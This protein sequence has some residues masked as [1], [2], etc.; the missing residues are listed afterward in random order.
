MSKIRCQNSEGVYGDHLSWNWFKCLRVY[1][2]KCI[3]RNGVAEEKEYISIY[4][5]EVFK[6]LQRMLLNIKNKCN[7]KELLENSSKLIKKSLLWLRLWSVLF[8]LAFL[9]NMTLGRY[10]SEVRS[11]PCPVFN[12]EVTKHLGDIR[13]YFLRCTAL[14]WSQFEFYF[15]K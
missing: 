9:N 7:F 10:V 6:S 4:C 3:F 14:I 12:T 15:F 5:D 1:R 8:S 13:N 2:C 11:L